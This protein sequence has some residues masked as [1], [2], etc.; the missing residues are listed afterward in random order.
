MQFSWLNKKN[1]KELIIFF[2]G[3]GMDEDSIIL[4]YRDLD[5]LVFYN[6]TDSN[7]EGYLLEECLK[8]KHVYVIGWSMGV[9]MSTLITKQINNIKLKIAINGTPKVIDNEFGIPAKIFNSTLNNL[10][11]NTIKILF[12]NMGYSNFKCPKRNLESQLKELKFIENYY[13]NIDSSICNCANVDKI[14]LGKRDIIFPYR[15]QKKFWKN[16]S[17]ICLD[18]GHYIFNLFK[19][20]KEIINVK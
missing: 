5:F 13:K 1:N 9:I 2:T 11:E 18:S 12:K 17:C 7:L 16:Q 15:N 3:W 19:S 4:E 6:Y 20:W 10:N 14:L 8:Y